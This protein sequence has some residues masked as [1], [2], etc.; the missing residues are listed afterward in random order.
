MRVTLIDHSVNTSLE[1]E[2]ALLALDKFSQV[3][4]I[5]PLDLSYIIQNFHNIYILHY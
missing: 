5:K 1:D 2:H 4:N 3:E